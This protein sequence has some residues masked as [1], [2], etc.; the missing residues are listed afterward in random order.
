MGNVVDVP[1]EENRS[2]LSDA[3]R[4]FQD[5]D[6]TSLP[7]ARSARQLELVFESLGDCTEATKMRKIVDECLES[8]GLLLT[9][10]NS[11]YSEDFFT[12]LVLFKF[13]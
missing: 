3:L 11:G 10:C 5:I 1:H 4:V 12:K 8:H 6:A 2:F 7:A 13:S 9:A